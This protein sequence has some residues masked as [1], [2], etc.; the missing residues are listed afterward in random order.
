[1]LPV[2]GILLVDLLALLDHHGR[3]RAAG[4]GHELLVRALRSVTE[5]AASL[6]HA[7]QHLTPSRL[8]RRRARTRSVTRPCCM[9]VM[10]STCRTVARRCATTTLVQHRAAMSSPSAACTAA[11]LALSKAEV[12]SS[13]SSTRGV[14]S[15]ARAS[16]MRCF[17]PPLS[18]P[19]C[20]CAPPIHTQHGGRPLVSVEAP[21]PSPHPTASHP[22]LPKTGLQYR[23][24]VGASPACRIRPAA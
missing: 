7:P 1:M 4:Q 8:P 10:A 12:A 23:Q 20:T 13:S 15:T 3:V 5:R 11:S 22:V 19:P 6:S 21:A 18:R 9:T 24:R 17:C 16:A 2:L 14:R